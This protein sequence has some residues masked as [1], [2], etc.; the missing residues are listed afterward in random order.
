MDTLIARL[1]SEIDFIKRNMNTIS[2]H[3]AKEYWERRLQQLTDEL[4]M[5]KD[6]A[7]NS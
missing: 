2:N 1:Q 3:T 4:K 5:I 6:K 7:I